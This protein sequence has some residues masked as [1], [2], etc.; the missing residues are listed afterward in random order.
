MRLR[1][2]RSD[3]RDIEFDPAAGRTHSLVLPA[4]RSDTSPLQGFAA[5]ERSLWAARVAFA[6][7]RAGSQLFFNAGA[8]RWDL[9]ESGL[10]FSHRRF[11]LVSRFRVLESG[12]V[13]FT[14]WYAHI[15]RLLWEIVDPTYDGLD[16]E[17]DYF[18]LFVAE[19]ATT[20]GWQKSARE[21]WLSEPEI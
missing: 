11:G 20:A 1:D 19:Y 3:R 13:V 5:F 7:Y 4:P 15:G 21:R 18:L 17:Q 6:L 14:F 16:E 12:R 2:W 10:S 8:R 9:T